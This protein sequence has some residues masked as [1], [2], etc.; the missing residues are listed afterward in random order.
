MF[1][2]EI[3][4]LEFVGNTSLRSYDYVQGAKEWL[5]QWTC[6]GNYKMT[7]AETYNEAVT[8]LR[9]QL[10]EHF[11]KTESNRMLG[12]KA[13]DFVFEVAHSESS[14][15]LFSLPYTS[16]CRKYKIVLKTEDI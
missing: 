9:N 12:Y 8:N 4:N 1:F 15:N 10:L 6:R 11:K 14:D 13:E 7:F 5:T 2:A 3:T 16:F